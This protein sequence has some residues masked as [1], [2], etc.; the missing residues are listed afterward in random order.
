MKDDYDSDFID[1]DSDSD[2][3]KENFSPPESPH[4]Y[5]PDCVKDLKKEGYSIHEY[6]T[7]S[8]GA[9]DAAILTDLYCDETQCDDD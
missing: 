9:V 8:L 4:H 3:D 7:S 6:S 2:F 5:C 1:D